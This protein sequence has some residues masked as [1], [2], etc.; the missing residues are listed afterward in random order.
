MLFGPKHTVFSTNY[1]QTAQNVTIFI[2]IGAGDRPHPVVVPEKRN[3]KIGA[4]RGKK[5]E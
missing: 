2:L 3:D 5:G 4:L 1:G